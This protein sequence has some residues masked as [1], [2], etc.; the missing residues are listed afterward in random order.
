MAEDARARPCMTNSTEP[1]VALPAARADT[2]NQCAPRSSEPPK[3][4]VLG[5]TWKKFVVRRSARES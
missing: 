3:Q 5:P 2:M 1:C 4:L